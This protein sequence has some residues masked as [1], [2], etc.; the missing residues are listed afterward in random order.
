MAYE[1][2]YIPVGNGEKAGDAIA[3]R[4]GNL[5]GPR[6]EQRVVVI[7][8]GFQE[9]GE[10]LVQH[11]K[12]FYHTDFVD[13]VISTHPDADH[14]AGLYVVLEQLRVGTLLM[15]KPWDHA[16]EIKS[17]F[18]SKTLTTSG[19]KEKLE[20]SLGNASNLEDIAI[21]RGVSI[22]EPFQGGTMFNGILH[23]LG[24]SPQYY[25]SLLPLFR[26]TPEAKEGAGLIAPLFKAAKEAIRYIA[27]S[28]D[29]DLLNDDEDTTSAENNTSTIILFT[30]DGKK[31]LFT[32]DAG[33]T[34]LH[35][36]A[37]YAIRSGTTLTDLAF[38][39]V[40]HHGSKRNLSSNVLKKIRGERAYIS[41]PPN[42]TKHPAK[43]VINALKK[44]GMRVFVVKD[45]TI[46]HFSHD[47]PVREGWTTISEEPF[48]NVVEE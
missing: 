25:E 9:S 47:A 30:I 28:L 36:A 22:F 21:K 32:G 43:K 38:L 39:D 24:P 6:S 15:H 44:F 5:N 7:D 33:K 41:A 20:K 23:V 18:K 40:P 35:F 4:F 45:F 31:F 8:G 11:I 46:H 29:I 3:L 14:S 19:L 1:I 2:D 17:F 37:D 42:S 13:L 26:E 27:D 10:K 48:Y 34:A 16:A 12:N